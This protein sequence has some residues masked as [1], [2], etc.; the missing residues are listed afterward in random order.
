MNL[1]LT[2][3]FFTERADFLLWLRKNHTINI[4]LD[5]SVVFELLDNPDIIVDA[6]VIDEHLYSSPN[7]SI[8]F[9]WGLHRNFPE[10]PTIMII[11][12][13]DNYEDIFNLY[14][15]GGLFDVI[16]RYQIDSKSQFAAF[17][18][19]LFRIEQC[20]KRN[21]L[22]KDKFE[23]KV[24]Q[25]NNEL[26]FVKSEVSKDIQSKEHQTIDYLLS[27]LQ[28]ER[29]IFTQER[30]IFRSIFFKNADIKEENILKRIP[31]FEK[32][33]LGKSE[34]IKKFF[35]ETLKIISSDNNILVYGQSGKEIKD[36]A[37]FIHIFRNLFYEVPFIE[38]DCSVISN[39]DFQHEAFGQYKRIPNNRYVTNDGKQKIG[40][41]E[42]ANQGFLFINHIEQL[43]IHNQELL[44]NALKNGYIIPVGGSTKDHRV[45]IEFNLIVGSTKNL[46]TMLSK[47]EFKWHLLNYILQGEVLK[48]PGFHER[49][50]D[51]KYILHYTLINAGTNIVID[52]SAIQYLSKQEWP[53]GI[54]SV[55]HFVKDYLL[56][57]ENNDSVVIDIFRIEKLFG[58][59]CLNF[60]LKEDTNQN[61]L[62]K[63]HLNTKTISAVR[64]NL[65]LLE[66]T[67]NDYFED[68]D[69]IKIIDLDKLAYREFHDFIA[70]K[71]SGRGRKRTKECMT[72]NR[73]KIY[74]N[75]K[76]NQQRLA[77]KYLLTLHPEKW[78]LLRRVTF[79]NDILI[80]NT[81]LFKK[82]NIATEKSSILKPIN[83]NY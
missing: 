21:V 37:T 33:F 35:E 8:D 77:I 7:Q 75:G 38:L 53:E 48:I 68:F 26:N 14:Q 32:S 69:I 11:S 64:K 23:E 73:Y 81:E 42:Q 60:G 10:I 39:Q 25:L 71:K 46:S 72:T 54:I 50:D 51:F 4:E 12:P 9:A 17:K 40:K 56:S 55:E 34:R 30:E 58:K 83:I 43:N 18:A 3:K 62:Y 5:P 61:T 1:L 76:I 66:K 24:I 80:E 6:I 36:L 2:G 67:A 49:M 45:E 41:L 16:E 78:R 74:Q 79:F 47:G 44:Y 57:S 22:I 65:D 28:S 29:E 27:C 20:L 70:E 63:I 31:Y 59:Y 19:I 13:R 52:E 15:K 82:T